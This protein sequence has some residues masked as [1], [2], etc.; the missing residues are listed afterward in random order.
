[1]F[2]ITGFPDIEVLFPAILLLLERKYR[3]LSQG[4][5]YNRGS[6]IT[7]IEDSDCC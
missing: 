1:M 4:F 5:R 7:E 2:T 3:S 6:S